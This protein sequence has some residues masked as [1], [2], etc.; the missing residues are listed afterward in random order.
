MMPMLMVIDDGNL[1]NNTIQYTLF[2]IK[3]Y[4]ASSHYTKLC[5]AHERKVFYIIEMKKLFGDCNYN[6]IPLKLYS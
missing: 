5:S 4:N 1:Q 3:Q 2:S 6:R